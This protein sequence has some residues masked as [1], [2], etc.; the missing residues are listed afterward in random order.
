MTNAVV[1]KRFVLLSTSRSGTTYAMDMLRSHPEVFCQF[2]AFLERRDDDQFDPVFR[3]HIDVAMRLSDPSRFLNHLMTFTPG[4]PCVGFKM[5][6]S[7]NEEICRQLMA[8]TSVMK[9]ILERPNRLATFSSKAMARIHGRRN[10]RI[11]QNMRGEKID[12]GPKRFRRHVRA[13]DEEF[14]IFRQMSRGPV[15]DTTYE[16]LVTEGFDEVIEFLGLTPHDLR[17]DFKRVN[18][19]RIIDR[20]HEHQHDEIRDVLEELGHPEWADA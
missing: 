3:A 11:Q 20:F 6:F 15:L 13:R 4:P 8:D 10:N 2:E 18:P 16:R 1:E 19:G 14:D 17:S 9:I 5:W 7:Q 12:F